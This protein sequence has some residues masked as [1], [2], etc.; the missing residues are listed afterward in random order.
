MDAVQFLTKDVGELKISCDTFAEA[1]E[2]LRKAASSPELEAPKIGVV[3]YASPQSSDEFPFCGEYKM[4][5]SV[6]LSDVS[7]HEALD[8]LCSA[9]GY[10]LD[11]KYGEL[12]CFEVPYVTPNPRVHLSTDLKA[13]AYAGLR[14]VV[15]PGFQA[16]KMPLMEAV[17]LL[18]SS[19]A[20]V[21]G[22]RV[23][24][25]AVVD[26]QLRSRD[27]ISLFKDQAGQ[28]ISLNLSEV[29]FEDGL[30]YV[31]ELAGCTY[32]VSSEGWISI[33]EVPTLYHPK[34]WRVVSLEKFA[35]AMKWKPSD[36]MESDLVR[37]IRHNLEVDLTLK[38]HRASGRVYLSHLHPEEWRQL[39]Q[40]LD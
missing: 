3:S 27:S 22:K 13:S 14:R 25:I 8:L 31:S 12:R 16:D 7:G 18:R 24:P 40:L 11:L 2:Q 26:Y 28:P 37:W 20:K 5:V 17:D 38:I 32:Q 15:L 10:A 39:Q 35:R 30:R 4:E 21:S 33:H 9:C 1:V 36:V 34:H 19:A 6:N 23:L 29:S